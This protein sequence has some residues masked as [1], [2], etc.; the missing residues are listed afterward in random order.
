MRFLPARPFRPDSKL[1]VLFLSH[2]WNFVQL[3]LICRRSRFLSLA[4]AVVVPWI[5]LPLTDLA[6][7]SSIITLFC[8]LLRFVRFLFWVFIRDEVIGA[9]KVV[10]QL[11]HPFFKLLSDLCSWILNYVHS[12]NYI[13]IWTNSF[14]VCFEHQ[15]INYKLMLFFLTKSN[16]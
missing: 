4:M 15:N 5:S 9:A 8:W 1:K 6:S 13:S 7:N 3:G 10:V 12:I 14:S 16:H 11:F 2:S